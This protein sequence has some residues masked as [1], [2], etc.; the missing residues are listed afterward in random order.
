[1]ENFKKFKISKIN[2][3]KEKYIKEVF[4]IIQVLVLMEKLGIHLIFIEQIVDSG[5]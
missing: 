5:I 4:V 2:K 1:M 3:F